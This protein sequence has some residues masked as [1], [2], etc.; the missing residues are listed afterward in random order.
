MRRQPATG[1]RAA[2]RG[3]GTVEL[4]LGS[5]LFVTILLFGIHFA[6]VGVM[7]LR[8]QQA[9][10]SAL[11]DTTALRM[12]QLTSPGGAGPRF[13]HAGQVRDQQGRSPE[14]RAEALYRDFDAL[15][16]G[17]STFTQVVTQASGLQVSCTPSRIAPLPNESAY[18]PLRASYSHPTFGGQEVDG[19]GCNAQAQVRLFGVPERFV[20]R[21]QGNLFQAEHVRRRELTVCA[22]GRAQG[23]TCAGT[24]ELALDDWGLA[25]SG[26][27]F[28]RELDSCGLD[29]LYD[30]RGNQAYKQTVERIY[31]AYNPRS[32]RDF[33]IPDFIRALFTT[34]PVVPELNN[35][36]VEERTFRMVFAGE[37]GLEGTE[38]FQFRTRE[39]NTFQAYDFQWATTPYAATYRTAYEE[40]GRCFLGTPCDKSL[41]DKVS[42]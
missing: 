33:S 6:E 28:G 29:C 27:A 39:Q 21:S 20:E 42:W 37:D 18:V 19:M 34:S 10:N 25:G 15:A 2:R 38:P 40:R 7:K 30:E 32:E 14:A 41:F 36:P 26:A 16:E 11:W 1:R 12:H 24:V 4:A 23:G 31:S 8:V 5:L 3:Q 9:A 35:V 13:L 17:A 22:F